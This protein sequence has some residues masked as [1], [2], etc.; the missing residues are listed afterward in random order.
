MNLAI[1]G[2][3]FSSK[4][5]INLL[6]FKDIRWNEYHEMLNILVLPGMSQVRN[7]YWKNCQLCLLAYIMKKVVQLKYTLINLKFTDL[8]IFVLSHEWI[9]NFGSI[10]MK[11]IIKYSSGHRLKNLKI[12]TCDEFSFAACCQG[13]LI[14]SPSPMKVDIDSLM[15]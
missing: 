5:P 10:M 9:G 15:F 6:C 8:D 3:L 14:T 11:W 1:K 2:E 7:I 12:L 13:K 4:S